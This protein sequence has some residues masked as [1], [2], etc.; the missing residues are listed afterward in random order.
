MKV[1]L[2][3]FNRP[4]SIIGEPVFEDE[5]FFVIQNDLFRRK[6]LWDNILYFEEIIDATKAQVSSTEQN[7]IQDPKIQNLIKQAV[8]LKSRKVSPDV[9]SSIKHDLNVSQIEPEELVHA[10][11]NQETKE[12]T[13][14]FSGFKTDS[15]TIAV[16]A[17]IINGSYSPSLGKEIFSNPS[18]QGIMGDFV[19]VGKPTVKGNNVYFETKSAQDL[20]SKVDAIGSMMGTVAKA[21][22]TMNKYGQMPSMSLDN[23]FS[24]SASPFE[25]P[26]LFSA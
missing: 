25:K 22:N 17:S 24:M 13:V 16:P 21:S 18:I 1:Y 19:V 20:K 11:D 26:V 5:R 14:V 4:I 9:K 12:I 2:K 10:G 15:I 8:E 23:S 7:I 3:G 6:I